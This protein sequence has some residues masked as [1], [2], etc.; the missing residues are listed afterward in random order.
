MRVSVQQG[1]CYRLGAISAAPARAP[2]RRSVRDGLDQGDAIAIRVAEVRHRGYE[3]L[4]AVPHVL[5]LDA[6]RAELDHR[7][8]KIGRVETE[9]CT[10]AGL[11]ITPRSPPTSPTSTERW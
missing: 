8:F 1:E 9:G 6:A 4:C 7:C 10:A 3:A 5:E 11:W 2:R